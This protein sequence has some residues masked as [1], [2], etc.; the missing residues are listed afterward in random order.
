MTRAV[1][2]QLAAAA[3]L[4]LVAGHAITRT[5]AEMALLAAASGARGAW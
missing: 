4:A 5:L 1:L 2:V 3:L